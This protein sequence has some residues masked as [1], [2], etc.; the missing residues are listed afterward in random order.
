MSQPPPS[1][2]KSATPESSGRLFKILSHPLR[3]RIL[4]SLHEM[5][6]GSPTQL[7]GRL[8][9]PVGNVSYHVKVLAEADAIELTRTEP[10][11]GALEHF[12]RPI[13]RAEIDDDHW[14]QL[15]ASVR[16]RLFDDAIQDIWDCVVAARG[17]DG[18]DGE[19]A[20]ASLTRLRLDQEGHSAVADVLDEA[21]Q[22]LLAIEAEV[23]SRA[24]KADGALTSTEV[25][26]L[27]FERE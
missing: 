8:D 4:T 19:R 21:L 5:E 27:R 18:F 17:K 14:S 9:E 6:E 24:A 7:A 15:P 1:K 20:H 13:T 3:H 10:R 12:Y 23:K 11:R 25:A 16:S 22:R 26:I 2:Q